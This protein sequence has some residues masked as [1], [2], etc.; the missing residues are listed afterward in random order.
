MIMPDGLWL[1]IGLAAQIA[2]GARFIVQWIASE[3]ARASLLPEHFWRFSVLGSVLMLAYAVHQRDP[4][5]MTGQALG[6]AI[7]LRNLQLMAQ[8][9]GGRVRSFLWPWLLLGALAGVAGTLASPAPLSALMERAPSGWLVLGFIGQ[10]LFTG[11]FVVQWLASERSGAPSNPV[12][13]WYLSIIGSGLLL[14]YAI[15]TGD[16]VVILGQSL[17]MAVYLRNLQL[18]RHPAAAGEAD[19]P[20]ALR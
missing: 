8:A 19:A 2:F 20:Q 6:L 16:P 11:R 12:A 9:A 7:Y 18:W 13:F 4:V 15:E 1:A 5:I 17:G 10:T 3:R 14:A